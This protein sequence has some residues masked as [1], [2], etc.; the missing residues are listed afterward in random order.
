MQN[1]FESMYRRTAF[2]RREEQWSHVPYQKELAL[3]ESVKRGELE[4]LDCLLTEIF[5]AHDGHL[6]DDPHRQAIY[7]FVAGIT[8]VTRFAV[9]GGAN[10][11]QAY[12]LSDTYIKFADQT[13]TLAEIH[14]LYVKMLVDFTTLAKRA[15]KAKKPLPLPIIRAMEYIDSNLHGKI[16]LTDIAQAINRNPAY[17]CCLFKE[18]TGIPLSKYINREKIEA[19][20][21]LLRDTDM[22]IAE[23]SATLAF[24]SQSYFAKLFYEFTG[25][26]PKSFR[27]KRVMQHG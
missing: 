15:K 1:H 22:A 25:E 13:K 12:T 4:K 14:D 20:K 26:T 24:G 21:H 18:E 5:P 2:A 10:T 11:E 8:L 7:E 9:E 19:S 23:I 27:Q 6:S 16:T 3:L 17:L